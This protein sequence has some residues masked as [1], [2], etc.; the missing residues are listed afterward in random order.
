[1]PS[2]GFQADSPSLQCMFL[3][4]EQTGSSPDIYHAWAVALDALKLARFMIGRASNG[5][6]EWRL[7]WGRPSVC[8]P[9]AETKI[10]LK[11]KS[12]EISTEEVVP[13][14]RGVRQ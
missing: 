13:A 3:L 9:K 4:S 1:M 11:N 10:M 12:K 5:G 8:A 6:N 14:A 7:V 2:I